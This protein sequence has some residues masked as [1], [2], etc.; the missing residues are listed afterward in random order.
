MSDQSRT[1]EV[2]LTEHALEKL[3]EYLAHHE[4]DIAWSLDDF[5][6]LKPLSAELGDLINLRRKADLP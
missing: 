5:G 6:D 2:R 1:I 3:V 4:D